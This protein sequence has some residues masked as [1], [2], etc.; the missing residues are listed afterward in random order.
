MEESRQPGKHF[1]FK[2]SARAACLVKG[3]VD[4]GGLPALEGVPEERGDHNL[5]WVLVSPLHF[6][7]QRF[8]LSVERHLCEPRARPASFS[9]FLSPSVA[10]VRKLQHASVPDL[11]RVRAGKSVSRCIRY[12]PTTGN[13]PAQH[14]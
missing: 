5:F 13:R 1:G 3:T 9:F 2:A 14:A 8:R 12:T 6:S 7:P 4:D 11:G 10:E